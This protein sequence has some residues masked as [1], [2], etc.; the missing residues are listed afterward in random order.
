MKN[1]FGFRRLMPALLAGIALIGAP[2]PAKEIPKDAHS[3]SGYAIDG[4]ASAS[5][6]AAKRSHKVARDDEIGL[7]V[8]SGLFVIAIIGFFS[9]KL[10]EKK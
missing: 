7:S 5:V 1:H 10:F 8:F 6:L 3:K 9:S 2:V 4:S